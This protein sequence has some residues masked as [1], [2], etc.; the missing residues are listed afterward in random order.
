MTTPSGAATSGSASSFCATGFTGAPSDSES[1]AR[2]IRADLEA[3]KQGFSALSAANLETLEDLYT[4]DVEFEDAFH[5]IAG[6]AA[7]RRYFA[8]LYASL[9]EIGFE[10]EESLCDGNI[11][12][13]SWRMR[14]RHPRVKRGRTIIVSGCSLLWFRDGLVYKHR[15]Y[16]DAG[17]LLY[18][19]L[20]VVGSLVK[21]IKAQFG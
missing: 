21:W 16:F 18:E 2:D 6:C 13:L 8:S 11:A 15:D 20:P 17:E 1:G 12:T 10:F 4:D 3:F 5:K 19:Q 9:S 7:L 14:Y